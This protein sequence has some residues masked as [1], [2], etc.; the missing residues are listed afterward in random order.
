MVLYIDAIDRLV[1]G[2]RLAVIVRNIHYSPLFVQ[3]VYVL[4]LKD[5]DK[6][7]GSIAP[8]DVGNAAIAQRIDLIVGLDAV[9]G[10]VVVIKIIRSQHIEFVAGL[11][12]LLYIVISHIGFPCANT[13]GVQH[14]GIEY[15][16]QTED[17][18]FHIQEMDYRLQIDLLSEKVSQLF[19]STRP[20]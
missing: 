3:Q 7:F 17:N 16:D 13:V 2:H 12:Y 15:T 9:V 14:A 6:P 1:F 4:V 8:G 11:F 19:H 10:R 20:V 5:D 18:L